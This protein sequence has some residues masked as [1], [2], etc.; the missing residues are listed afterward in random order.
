VLLFLVIVGFYTV[1]G[2][3]GVRQAV[4]VGAVVAACVSVALAWPLQQA[5]STWQPFGMTEVKRCEK[6]GAEPNDVGVCK[7][8]ETTDQLGWVA[9]PTMLIAT[10]TVLVLKHRAKAKGR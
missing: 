1:T 8:N 4:A 9:V 2:E 7:G 3:V 5:L 6:P 10:G